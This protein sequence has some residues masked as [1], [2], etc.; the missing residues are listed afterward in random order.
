MNSNV[1]L[2]VEDEALLLFEMETS[3]VEAGFEIISC[4]SG[5][6]AM[7]A[8]DAEPAR[9]KVVVTDIRL[10]EG[11]T[12]WD[13]ARHVR[14]VTPTMPIVYVSGDGALDWESR[15]VPGSI[16]ISKPFVMT[17]IITAVSTLLNQ[18]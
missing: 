16:M 7:A 6:Q 14:E 9:F 3:L 1:I 8:F 13:L 17:Q 15:G 12:G 5:F 18:S 4:V 11:P 2:L 10:G